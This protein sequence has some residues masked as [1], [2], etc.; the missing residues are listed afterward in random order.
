VP[1]VQCSLGDVPSDAD[2]VRHVPVH[3]PQLRLSQDEDEDAAAPINQSLRM[4]P[5]MRAPQAATPP[6]PT[7]S[8]SLRR[9]RGVSSSTTACA[10]SR[11]A[12]T[13]VA[14]PCGSC[15]CRYLA[16]ARHDLYARLRAG[17]I[18]MRACDG[19]AHQ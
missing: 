9:I 15:S 1:D 10:R 19:R 16:S 7:R 2:A 5:S 14:M 3:G 18:N 8:S 11:S 13:H 4:A 17:I 6:R 12:S